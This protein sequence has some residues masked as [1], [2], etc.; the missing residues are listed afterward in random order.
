MFN[1]NNTYF[2]SDTHFYHKNIIKY[3]NRPFN[4]I[5]EMNDTIINN[6]NSIVK[7]NDYVFHLGD[8]SFSNITLIKE[9]LN[10]L[11][12]IKYLILG[13]HDNISSNLDEYFQYITNY[14]SINIQDEDNKQQIILCH[15]PFIEWDR[16][17]YGSWNLHGH[18]HGTLQTK[19]QNQLD[20]G[21]NNHNYFPLSYDEVKQ[22]ILLNLK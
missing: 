5:E 6:W 21:V 4:S 18:C 15:Y 10:K 2:T 17:H 9:L 14:M 8:F 7:P 16:K 3:D 19:I 12:G 11:N 20:V 1:K 22:K 13:N